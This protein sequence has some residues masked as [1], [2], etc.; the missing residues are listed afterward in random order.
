VL[1]LLLLQCCYAYM[2]WEKLPQAI[3][4]NCQ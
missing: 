2:A 3:A 4:V 1:L